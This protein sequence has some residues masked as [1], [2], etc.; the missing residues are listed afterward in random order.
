MELGDC[1][2]R[3]AAVLWDATKEHATLFAPGQIVK[4]RGLVGTYQDQPQIRVDRIRGAKPDEYDL[5][6]YFRKASKTTEELGAQLDAMIA[7]LENSYLHQLMEAIFADEIRDRYLISPAAKLLHHDVIGGL[8][9]HSLSMAEIVVRLADHYPKLDRDLLIC[10]AL[11]HDIGKIREYEV[12]AA[13]EYSDIGRLVGHI[14][15]GD[16]LVVERAGTIEHFPD[17]LLM[18]L[19]RRFFFIT[20]MNWTP[21]WGRLKRSASAPATRAG[22]SGARSFRGSSFSGGRPRRMKRKNRR[23]GSVDSADGWRDCSDPSL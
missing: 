21:G 7:R 5:G 20:W 12:Q 3:I 8:A 18:H 16:E 23:A 15:M 6:D 10:G 14:A 17:D 22:R 13:I 9:E 2:G 11:L 1:T 19:R 4:V